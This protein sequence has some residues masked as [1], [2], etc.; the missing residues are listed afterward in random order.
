MLCY[1]HFD[2]CVFFQDTIAPIRLLKNS[3]DPFEPEPLPNKETHRNPHQRE[4]M[5]K[6]KPED[7]ENTLLHRAIPLSLRNRIGRSFQCVSEA[8]PEKIDLNFLFFGGGRSVLDQL[9]S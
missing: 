9:L 7:E 5:Q 2:E 6:N 3:K 8:C 4:V 1:P